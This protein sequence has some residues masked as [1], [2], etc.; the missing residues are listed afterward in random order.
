[1]NSSHIEGM[2]ESILPT[3][4]VPST[5]AWQ[6]AAMRRLFFYGVLAMHNIMVE[7]ARDDSPGAPKRNRELL[8]EIACELAVAFDKDTQPHGHA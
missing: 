2:W 6:V 5:P 1:M 7:I 8:Q 4:T 3:V